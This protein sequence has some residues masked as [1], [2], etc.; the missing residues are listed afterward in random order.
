[1]NKIFTLAL[2]MLL[3][4][5]AMMAQEGIVFVDA[6]VG[7]NVVADGAEITVT[8]YENGQISSG[9]YVSNTSAWGQNIIVEYD[10]QTLPSGSTQICFPM[11]C[12]SQTKTGTYETPYGSMRSGAT[13]SLQAEWMN[14]TDYGVST[15]TYSIKYIEVN[16]DFSTSY[17]GDGPSV[18]V[19]YKYADPAGV[20][21]VENKAEA[22]STEYFDLAGQRVATPHDGVYVVRTTYNNGKTIASKVVLK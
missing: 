6:E 17:I 7:G 5:T 3:S 14:P 4:S 18:T 16:D 22:K 2:G 8:D 10:V 1:M 12:V 21:S 11:A 9:L 15:V 19:N 13:L 20:N